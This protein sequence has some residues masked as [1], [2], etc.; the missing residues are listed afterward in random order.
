MHRALPPAEH[1]PRL[2]SYTVPMVVEQ[3]S[4]GERG[5]DIFSLL[6]KNRIVFL[7]TPI[8]DVVANLI[9]AQLLYLAQDDPE[10]EVQMYINSPGGA[11]DAGLAIYDTMHLIQ[12]PVA[13]TC[14]GMAASMGAVLLGGGAQGKR[15]ALPNSRILIHQA[16]AGFQGTAADIEVQAREILRMNA[17]LQEMLAADTGQSVERIAHDVNRDYWMSAGEAKDYGVIDTIV[18][19]TAAADRAE[20]AVKETTAGPAD[21]GARSPNGQRQP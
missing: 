11:V 14:V 20:A 12:P 21:A 13:T 2:V 19:Q 9:I 1:A 8:D 5:Y 16:S 4:R 6:L 3:T 15:A 18:G 17:R 10:H 7:G